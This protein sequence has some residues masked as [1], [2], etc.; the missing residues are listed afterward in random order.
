MMEVLRSDW[1]PLATTTL[2]P[3][4]FALDADEERAEVSKSLDEGLASFGSYSLDA[5]V[6]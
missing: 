4:A 5:S 6:M 1:N 3:Q 2:E